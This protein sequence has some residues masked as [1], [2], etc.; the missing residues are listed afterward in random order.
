MN[1]R[2]RSRSCTWGAA[3]WSWRQFD[4]RGPVLH[5]FSQQRSLDQWRNTI[6]LRVTVKPVFLAAL[7]NKSNPKVM[8]SSALIPNH[9]ILISLTHLNL[10]GKEVWIFMFTSSLLGEGGP[11]PMLPELWDTLTWHLT[12]LSYTPLYWVRNL[13]KRQKPCITLSNTRSLKSLYEWMNFWRAAHN[14]TYRSA[15]IFEPMR[16]LWMTHKK[17]WRLI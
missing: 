17:R 11:W 9:Q 15:S 14:V 6:T 3:S 5:P 1:N 2:T 13:L 7:H 10:P 4:G 8:F 12:S 16:K